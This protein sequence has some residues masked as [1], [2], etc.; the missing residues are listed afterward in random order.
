MN[1]PSDDLGIREHLAGLAAR[2]LTLPEFN[3]WFGASVLRAEADA[4]AEDWE[5]YL[6]VEN[7]LAQWA[8]GHLDEETATDALATE[9]ARAEPTVAR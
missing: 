8:L 1:P 3:R 7:V 6:T 9:L 5:L 4:T 2:T